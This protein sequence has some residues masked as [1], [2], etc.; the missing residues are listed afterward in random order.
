M[1]AVHGIIATAFGEEFLRYVLAVPDESPI[2][3]EA[4]N[5]RQDVIQE[6]FEKAVAVHGSADP[7]AASLLAM[8]FFVSYDEDLQT[9]RANAMR[10]RSGG[11]LPELPGETSDRFFDVMCRVARD[12]WASYFLLAPST[13]GARTFFA[14]APIGV[15]QHPLLGEIYKALLSDPTLAKLFPELTPEAS[16]GEISGHNAVW[17]VNGGMSG[18]KSPI[19]VLSG[20]IFDAS[21]R[22]RLVGERLSFDSLVLHLRESIDTLRALADGQTVHVPAV[23]GYSGVRLSG[24]SSISLSEGKFR[25]VRPV[26]SDLLFGSGRDVTVVY[27]TTFPLRIL[28]ITENDF[29]AISSAQSKKYAE[30]SQEAHRVFE[31]SLD[32]ARLSL[33][34]SSEGEDFLST[35]ERSRFISDVTNMGGVM[36]ARVIDSQLPNQE[37]AADRVDGVVD[38]HNVIRQS[39][40]ESLDIAMRRILL[41]ASSRDEPTDA[42]ID[43]LIAWENIFGTHMETTFR[44]TASLAKLIEDDQDERRELQKVLSKI[45]G[46]R[47]KL[48][49]GAKE[50]SL[51]VSNAQ[52]VKAIR[53]ALDGLRA[54]YI[55]RPDLLGFK[56][57]ERSMRLLLEG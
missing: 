31:R 43:A 17:Y 37:I 47:S 13:E 26:E 1:D 32:L 28:A 44:V 38:V 22:A 2:D 49:H 6:L 8:S 4:A 50:L 20:L 14:A 56:S 24:I 55:D 45:Y 7:L 54:L 29:N 23:I 19:A 3:L 21:V 40:P 27:E 53:V 42:L 46:S 48:V 41:A 39:H 34:L 35:L 12:L 11:A 57:E 51:D 15:I 16:N 18:S 10:E 5:I 36:A 9:S 52:R 33:L 25:H 30:S